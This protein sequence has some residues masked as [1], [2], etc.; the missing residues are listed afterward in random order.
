MIP[1]FWEK[2]MITLPFQS[3]QN[4]TTHKEVEFHNMLKEN[5]AREFIKTNCLVVYTK[6]RIFVFNF[7][8]TEMVWKYE[9]NMKLWIGVA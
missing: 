6:Y 8:E 3:N 1:G 5:L 9:E 7:L 4:W 2:P